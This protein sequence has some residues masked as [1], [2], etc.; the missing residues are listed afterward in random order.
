MLQG[1]L[2]LMQFIPALRAERIFIEIHQ[3]FSCNGLR[4][5]DWSGR[6]ILFYRWA[7]VHPECY[8]WHGR[9]PECPMA[10]CLVSVGVMEGMVFR[11]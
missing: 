1:I 2:R 5:L 8:K 4:Q 3:E 11:V 7:M 6:Q 10:V 9:V